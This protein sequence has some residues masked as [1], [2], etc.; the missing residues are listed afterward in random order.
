M[1][2]TL[3]FHENLD[4]TETLHSFETVSALLGNTPA[5]EERIH[6]FADKMRVPPLGEYIARPRLCRLLEKSCAQ[7]G[8]TLVTGRAESGKTVLAADYAR[9]YRKVAWY[10]IDATES[11]WP[12]FARYLA[13]VCEQDYEPLAAAAGEEV[14]LFVER[15]VQQTAARD[16]E[17]RLV[18]LDD[19]HQVFDAPWFAEF[20]VS[21]LSALAPPLHL[22]MLSRLKPPQPLWRLRSKQVLGVIDEKLLSFNVDETAAFLDQNKISPALAPLAHAQTFGRIAALKKQ[23]RIEN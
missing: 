20:F 12:L 23:L 17:Q 14:Q 19:I 7:I 22:V 9:G 3:S 6:L 10:Q 2:M 16:D 13:A 15:L 18:V 5:A 1:A 4:L 8:A 11:E 21:L